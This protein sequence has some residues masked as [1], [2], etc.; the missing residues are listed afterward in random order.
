MQ[1]HCIVFTERNSLS[2]RSISILMLVGK[3][4]RELFDS[5]SSFCMNALFTEPLTLRALSELLP[6]FY[7]GI[8]SKAVIDY[9]L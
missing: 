9:W 6:Y 7:F 5:N 8:I 2:L 1:T 4:N 3:E